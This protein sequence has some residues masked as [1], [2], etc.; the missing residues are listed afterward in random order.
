[1]SRLVKCPQQHIWLPTGNF[2]SPA[3]LTCP[4]CGEIVHE[5]PAEAPNSTI[6]PDK[7]DVTAVATVKSDQSAS[8]TKSTFAPPVIP[9]YEIVRELG[10]GGMGVV[11]LA[12]HQQLKRLVAL[13][14]ILAGAH[15]GPDALARFH[16]EAEAVARLQHP[17]I[18]QIY[19]VGE[20]EGRPFLTLEYIDGGSLADRLAEATLKPRTSAALVEALARTIHFAHQCGIVHRDLTP[21]NILL[22]KGGSLHSD[23]SVTTSSQ[24]FEPKITD[25]GLAKELDA[26]HTQT[27]TGAVLGTPSYMSPEQ[28]QGKTHE[29]GPRSD[30]YALGAILYQTLTGR[31][32]YLA[33]TT[34]DTLKQVIEREPVLPTRLQPS[35]P[36]DL[37][38]ICLKCLAKDAQKRYSS[39][40][41]LANDLHRF[42]AS[43]PIHARRVPWPERTWKWAR[44]Q[45]AVAALIVVVLLAAA[46]FGVG[47]VVYNARVRGE[48]DRAEHNFQL[49]MRAVDEMLTEVGQEQLA[50]E[51]RMEEK[52]R[53]CWQMRWHFI[54]SFL[55]RNR[56]IPASA[57]KRRRRIGD[58]PMCSV[59]WDKMVLPEMH[60]IKRSVCSCSYSTNRPAT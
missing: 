33:A 20:Q 26:D 54:K 58:W 9:G 15:A 47:S 40:E 59:Y 34:F 41:D 24:S 38:T 42:L 44:R 55:R 27:M 37:E 12:R 21:R 57:W 2:D 51:P 5:L 19:D 46:G 53:A 23:S 52:R 22:G 30:V 17:G 31:P 11:Y 60:T 10:R 1:M 13:K 32:P 25:F 45:P 6:A 16:R 39:A 36:R 43:E 56:T 28:A 14:M 3:A 48:R 50:S 49:A 4:V 18:T 29:I 35:V 8:H 7:D